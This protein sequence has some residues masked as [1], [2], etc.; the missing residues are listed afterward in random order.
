M[1]DSKNNHSSLS[2][3]DIV[4]LEKAINEAIENLIVAMNLGKTYL[5]SESFI[6]TLK[7]LL[8]KLEDSE[9]KKI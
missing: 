3:E 9:R 1:A 5:P 2:D 8:K 7:L 6:K 4:F